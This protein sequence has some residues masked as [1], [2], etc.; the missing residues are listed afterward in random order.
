VTA[1]Y[2]VRLREGAAGHVATATV[3]WLDP[4]T[5]KAHEETGS[6]GTG[7]I[8]GKLWDGAGARLQVTAVAAYFAD[9]LRGGDLPG[10][11][12]LGELAARARKLAATTEDSSVE[13]LATAI[14]QADRIRN[15]GGEEPPGGEGEGEL[16]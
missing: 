9:T 1:L 6:V 3:R 13:K 7:A 2:A 11:P 4:K 10:A 15:G 16:G 5:R 8:G 12:A 14:G